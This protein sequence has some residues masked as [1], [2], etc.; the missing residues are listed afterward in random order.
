MV[1]FALGESAAGSLRRLGYPVE[2]HAYPVEH[3]VSAEEVG[4]IGAWLRQHLT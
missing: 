3:T 4:D 1:P 2:W